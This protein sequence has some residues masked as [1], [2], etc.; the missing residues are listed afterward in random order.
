MYPCVST[1]KIMSSLC[2]QK[3]QL[4]LSME[5]LKCKIYKQ[6]LEQKLSITLEDDVEELISDVVER[7]VTWEDKKRKSN[8]MEVFNSNA[9]S[10]RIEKGLKFAT[11]KKNSDKNQKKEDKVEK[12]EFDKGEEKGKKDEEKDNAEVDKKEESDEKSDDEDEESDN[13]EDFFDLY[14]E[15]EEQR[16]EDLYVISE[17]ENK[18]NNLFLALEKTKIHSYTTML[19]EIRQLRFSKLELA[20]F[21]DYL[22]TI[23]DHFQKIKHVFEK[24]GFSEVKIANS[25]FPVF[26]SPLEYRIL[27][28]DNL[29]KH[30]LEPDEIVKFKSCLS[31]PTPEQFR[32]FCL[33]DFTSYLLTYAI[34]FTSLHDLITLY[35]SHSENIIFV[36]HQSKEDFAFYTLQSISHSVDSEIIKQWKMDCRLENLTLDLS[37]IVT[38]YCIHLFRSLYKKCLGTNNYISGYENKCSVLEFECEQLLQTIFIAS[39][40]HKLNRLLQNCVPFYFYF[41]S[42]DKFDL[43]KEDKDQLANFK[44]YTMTPEN[45]SSIFHRLFDDIDKE[46]E[47]NMSMRLL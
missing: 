4:A 3:L 31:I 2:V 44:T 41:N 42:S 8:S 7:F 18:I 21:K 13:E 43:K 46:N 24:K 19:C 38:N 15:E 32:P 29:Q 33:D 1:K 40:F 37:E 47:K 23:E 28:L 5:K 17:M 9:K 6:I 25:I 14:D 16:E 39:D 20:G 12:K 26:F 22:K 36:Q 45:V 35:F 27:Q 11:K 30:T 10:A 34:A